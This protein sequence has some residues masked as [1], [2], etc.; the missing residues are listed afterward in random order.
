MGSRQYL[1]GG[2]TAAMLLLAPACESWSAPSQLGQTDSGIDGCPLPPPGVPAVITLHNLGP[3][4]PQL[5]AHIRDGLAASRSWYQEGRGVHYFRKFY[6]AYAGR[7]TTQPS[8]TGG[9][10]LTDAFYCGEHDGVP[11]YT[12]P[13]LHPYPLIIYVQLDSSHFQPYIEASEVA[14]F[15]DR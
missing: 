10:P 11:I 15:F 6:V 1:L 12:T 9:G 13:P 8:T 4:R 2:I 5:S 7:R 14:C 3:Q